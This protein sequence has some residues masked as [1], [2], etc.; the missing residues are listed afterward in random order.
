[1]KKIIWMSNI[2]LTLLLLSLLT[3]LITTVIVLISDTP[4]L[5]FS[6]ENGTNMWIGLEVSGSWASAAKQLTQNN[7]NAVIW[8]GLLQLLPFILINIILIRLFYLYRQGLFFN[9][10][11]ISCFTWLGTVLL[12]QFIIVAIYPA[13]L[14]TLLNY[15]TGSGL[16]RMVSINDTDIIG[17]LAGLII[18]VIAWV[19]KQAHQLQ[20]EQELVI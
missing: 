10:K 6:Q 3:M 2:I 16:G 14:F 19:M 4:L 5:N 20:Q 15:V 13:L 18:Y 9:P 8:L 11:N 12:A 17:L 1:M 7:F